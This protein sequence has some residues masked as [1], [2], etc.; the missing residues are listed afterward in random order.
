MSRDGGKRL[1]EHGRLSIGRRDV[2][3][4]V[5]GLDAKAAQFGAGAH[6]RNVMAVDEVAPGGRPPQANDA[7]IRKTPHE[8]DGD[9][10]HLRHALDGIELVCHRR[11]DNARRVG[12]RLEGVGRTPLLSLVLLGDLLAVKLLLYDGER[13]ELALL[14]IEDGLEPL[15][16]ARGVETIP[17][18]RTRR[19]EQPLVLKVADLGDRQ[20][21]ILPLQPPHDLSDGE[22]ACIGHGWTSY[23]PVAIFV[24]VRVV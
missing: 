14:E 21:R 5:L 22:V 12:Q 19:V 18:R 1:L 8:R 2:L 9:A 10:K 20:V 15:D 11:V 16:V 23:S 7:A 3:A 17:T 13:Q 6:E 4:Q 24:V